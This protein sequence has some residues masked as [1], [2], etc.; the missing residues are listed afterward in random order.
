[1]RFCSVFNQFIFLFFSCKG[2]FLY[3]LK[4]SPLSHICILQIFYPSCGLSSHSPDKVSFTEQ[5]FSILMRSSLSI[6]LFMDHALDIISKESSAYPRAF[7]FS[8][9]LSSESCII[10]CL[11]FRSMIYFE[12]L[13]LQRVKGTCIFLPMYLP[14]CYSIIFCEYTTLSSYFHLCQ[15]SALYIYHCVSL[16]LSLSTAAGIIHTDAVVVL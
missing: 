3:I 5:K 6:I 14:S 2:F 9:M 16:C 11:T 4:D 15:R 7:G 12:L 13:F 1:M 10:L 8:P